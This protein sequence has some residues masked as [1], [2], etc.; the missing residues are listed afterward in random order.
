MW[1]ELE[2]VWLVS[3]CR[4]SAL[5]LH[6]T[7]TRTYIQ[8]PV[9]QLSVPRLPCLV[10]TWQHLQCVTY[11]APACNISILV[12]LFLHSTDTQRKPVKPVGIPGISHRKFKRP[13]TNQPTWSDRIS[14][15]IIRS[16]TTT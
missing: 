4:A 5:S 2:Y 1:L 14:T 12:F 7:Y 16:H 6:T 11:Q 3:I 13:L 15:R 9:S 10:I 8:M